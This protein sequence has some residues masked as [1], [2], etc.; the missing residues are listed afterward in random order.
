MSGTLIRPAVADDVPAI[1]AIYN[2]YVEHSHA[3]FDL[4]PVSLENRRR[5]FANFA[6]AGPFRL[7]VAER[8]GE[9]LGYAGS[10]RFREKAAYLTSVEMT[11]YLR[12]EAVGQGLG[13]RLYEALFE[14]LSGEPI[15]RFY[16]GITQPNEASVALHRHFGFRDIGTY[17]EVG[18]KFE[19]YW[20]VLWL[21]RRGI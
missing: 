16:A 4:E 11:V 14:R 21:E 1:A 3:T 5:W 20:S 15:H 2:H 9:V 6:T 7:L 19:R 17:D 18:F 12:P 10:G 8:G 13:G